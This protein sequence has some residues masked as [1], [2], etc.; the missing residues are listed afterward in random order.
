MSARE[1]LAIAIRNGPRG[2]MLELT[3]V[4][5]L[6]DAG[7]RGDNRGSLNRGITLLSADQ[8]QHVQQELAV[9]LPW[10]TRRANLLISGGS[11]AD[12]RGRTIRIGR[13]E[14]AVRKETAP[15]ERMDELCPGLRAALQSDVRG[16]VHGR[17]LHGGTIRLGD[18]V[19]VLADD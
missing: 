11:L 12:W 17:I 18:R 15:C 1:V 8:W 9:T 14:V 5:A 7:L 16:G 13:V 10:H 19:D 4:G 3:D 2:P 6:T